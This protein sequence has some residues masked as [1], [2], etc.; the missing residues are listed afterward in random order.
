MIRGFFYKDIKPLIWWIRYNFSA[1]ASKDY[2]NLITFLLKFLEL[3]KEF[4]NIFC[5]IKGCWITVKGKLRRKAGDRKQKII[6]KW[7][8][9]KFSDLSVK[10]IEEST[11]AIT[12][13]GTIS[14]TIGVTY[15]WWF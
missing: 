5:N 9:Q 7:G 1:L 3:N 12:S 11:V 14:L 4:L 2:Q 6:I 15:G 13:K 10:F 8:C